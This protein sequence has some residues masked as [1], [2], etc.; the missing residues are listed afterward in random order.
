MLLLY[1]VVCIPAPR[2]SGFLVSMSKCN[3]PQSSVV[4][5]LLHMVRD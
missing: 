1:I 5:Q 2:E 4:R 3:R